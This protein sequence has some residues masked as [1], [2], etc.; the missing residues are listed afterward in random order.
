MASANLSP[1][2]Y[3]DTWNQRSI[4]CCD[5]EPLKSDENTPPAS[6]EDN[7]KITKF[8]EALFPASNTENLTDECPTSSAYV[9][10]VER[11]FTLREDQITQAR[12]FIPSDTEV[13]KY[14]EIHSKDI[15]SGTNPIEIKSNRQSTLMWHTCERHQRAGGRMVQRYVSLIHCE[16]R[17]NYAVPRLAGSWLKSGPVDGWVT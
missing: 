6:P 7:A 4:F 10:E 13:G 5:S 8:F 15:F 1:E 3:L 17:M 12:Y 14:D 11:I 16:W 2:D 9:L